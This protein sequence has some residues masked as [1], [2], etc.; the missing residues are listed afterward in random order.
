MCKGLELRSPPLNPPSFAE[1]DNTKIDNMKATS[2]HVKPAKGG[3]E[4]HN[5]RT[6]KLDHVFEDLTANNE[7]FT[8]QYSNTQRDT[9]FESETKIFRSLYTQKH[10]GRKPPKN[11]IPVKEAVVVIKEDTTME[12]LKHA[13]QRCQERWGIRGFQIDI[14]RD[15]GHT[16][17]DGS[18]KL[19]LHAHI[20][21]KWFLNKTGTTIKLNRWDMAEMQDI[22]AEELEMERGKSSSKKHLDAIQQKVQAE[23]NRLAE[24]ELQKEAT[25]SDKNKN[26][27]MGKLTAQLFRL[28]EKR[29]SDKELQDIFDACSP[30]SMARMREI[31]D[32]C[33]KKAIAAANATK[34]EEA[35]PAPAKNPMKL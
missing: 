4:K 18:R 28:L 32:E 27:Q 24:L 22:F 29:K 11:A 6:K 33:K 1:P 2:V 17:S 13:C 3:C 14:H 19:N 25:I 10:N 7:S 12:Q 34:K 16:A 26:E 31:I 20:L 15:E 5:R 21:F 9:T 30:I 23:L 8:A 35:K